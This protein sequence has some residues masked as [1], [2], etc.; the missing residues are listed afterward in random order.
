MTGPLLEVS[1]TVVEETVRLAA[2]EVPGVCRVGRGGPVWA[3]WLAEPAVRIDRHDG[4]VV[5][6]VAVVARPAQPLVQ[7]TRAV[8][9]SIA[10]AVERTLELE[11]GPISVIV[12]GIGV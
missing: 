3:R 9:T 4:S 11:A 7:L 5:V 10:A 8:R 1:S 2:L 12:D 6:S